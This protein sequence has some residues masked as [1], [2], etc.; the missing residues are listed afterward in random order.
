MVNRKQ[1]PE[2]R[3]ID[4][5]EFVKPHIFDIT[6]WSKLYF[7]KEVPNETS[8]VDLYFNAGSVRG[9]VGIAS[10]VNGLL[11][12]GTADLSSTEI[13]NQLDGLGAF[14]ESNVGH[15]NATISIY[16]LR[17]NMIYILH[18][19]KNAIHNMAFNEQEVQELISDRKQKFR[20]NLEKVSFLAQRQFQKEI[21]YNSPYGRVM[22]EEDYDAFSIPEMK[23]FFREN[24]LNGLTKVVVV[25]NFT[26]DDIDA[27]I[28]LTGPWS[29][30]GPVDF[31]TAFQNK[32]GTT[33]VEKKDAL[34]T[35]IRMG[36]ILFNKSH[37]DFIEF[38][39]LNT[40]LGDYFGSRLMSNIRE[41]KGYTYGIG[42]MSAELQETGYF[43]IA[44]E[45][46]KEVKDA[47]LSEIKKEIERLQ[48]ELVDEGE[49]ELVKSYLLGQL[50][51]SAD[52]AYSLIDLYMGLESFGLELE[53]YNQSI[54][55]IKKISPERIRELAN[56][57]L[58]WEDFSIVSA[59]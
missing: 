26:Q 5:I 45:V 23:N 38:Q 53:Y 51:K 7:M 32:P 25:G 8:R 39:V 42:S 19:L 2:L 3:S 59:G 37:P 20:V 36:K 1:S 55:A 15:E 56:Q 17:E 22:E 49:L 35:A 13:H 34:Q 33:H 40:I 18:V 47:T 57:Y 10:I 44:T 43:L 29:K 12:S 48:T 31:E 16:A 28:D 52:G 46:G 41:D 11:L 9:N 58:N 50:L 4:H 54:E 24:Y 6:P 30:E 14:Y 21:F 27:M